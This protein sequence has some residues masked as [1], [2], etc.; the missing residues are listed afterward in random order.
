MRVHAPALA[1]RAVRRGVDA[2]REA[3][4]LERP[5]ARDRG[6]LVVVM[7]E[8]PLAV[9]AGVVAVLAQH[10]SPGWKAGVERAAARDHAAGLVRVE[11][12]QQRRARRAAVVGGGVVAGEG[13]RPF[14]QAREVGRQAERR[15]GRGRTTAGS[16]AGRRRSRGCWAGGCAPRAWRATGARAWPAGIDWW[17]TSRW[18]RRPI[19]ADREP[20]AGE[21]AAGD[22]PALQERASIDSPMLLWIDVLHARSHPRAGRGRC[23]W[24]LAAAEPPP[25]RPG[26]ALHSRGTEQL[27][28]AGRI[29]DGLAAAGQP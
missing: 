19:G 27:R 14:A 9:P 21:H 23:G 13:D 5:F 10:R 6:P 1:G 20:G 16:A 17:R 15:P 18:W 4:A 7:G 22:Q 25:A 29:R 28:P 8:M 26:P 12:G 2:A 24:G 11:T 3:V